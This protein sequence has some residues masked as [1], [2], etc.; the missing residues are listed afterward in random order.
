M[1]TYSRP[2]VFIEEVE[3]PQTIEVADSGQ[4]IG[5]F[6]GAL[7]KGP[8]S[9][10][11][12]VDTWAKFTQIFGS[13]NDAYPTTW[14]AYN[15]FANGG[16]Q[17]YVKRVTG[18]GAASA[19]TMITDSSTNQL[20]TILLQAA[21]PGS[22]GNALAVQIR[23]TT[24]PTR[25]SLAVF[26]APTIAGNLTSNLLEQI[27]DLSMSST[28]PRYFV[29]T[30][31]TSSSYIIAYDQHSASVAPNNMPVLGTT[32]YALGSTTAGTDGDTPTRSNYAVALAALDPI[33]NPLVINNT[34]APYIYTTSGSGTDRSNALNIM[35]DVVAYCEGRGDGFAVLETPAGLSAADAEQFAVDLAAAYAG[36]SNGTRAAIYYPWL[37]IPDVK[38]SV[39]GVTRL[40]A[41]GA[42]VVGQYLATDASR[43]VF[44]TP[45]GL[46]N[47]IALAVATE[48]QFSNAELDTLNTATRPINAIRQ[49]PGAGIVIMGGRTMDTDV[50]NRYI[51][52]R[53]SLTYIEKECKDLTQFAVFENNDTY[54]WTKINVAITNFLAAYW[55][56]GGLRGATA[57]QAFYVKCDSTTTSATDISNG[58]VNIEVGVALQYPAE[59]VVI[60]IGQLTGSAT[61]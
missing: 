41:P 4:A 33:N 53:R 45:A 49:V 35:S 58:L 27:P 19:Q 52:I 6:V 10:P 14:A 59:F 20:N 1:A 60:K 37:V 21:N 36:S 61:A 12:L 2:G 9:V 40:Q 7:P 28:D 51:N 25:F 29:T 15:F 57:A 34:D 46:G 56:N 17:L 3:L 32:L 47:K 11:V 16:R 22:W 24:D 44:K 48:H 55:Q 38:R 13:L 23:P 5:A 26:G 43:G 39:P 31:N 18:S 8:T 30:I 54:L 50:R 42:S